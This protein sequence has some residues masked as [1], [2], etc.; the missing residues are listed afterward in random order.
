MLDN[1]CHK[2]VM[3]ASS[4]GLDQ[5]RLGTLRF[6]TAV[7]TNLSGDHLDY[8]KSMEEYHNAKEKLFTEYLAPEGKAIIN[9]DDS[10]ALK[11]AR[12]LSS[13]KVVT[14]GTSIKADCVFRIIRETASGTHAELRYAGFQRE[15]HSPLPGIHNIYNLTGA[16]LASVSMGVPPEFASDFFENEF[17][18]PGRLEKYRAPDGAFCFIDY[19]HTDDALENVLRVLKKICAGRLICV[20]G[21]GGDRDKAKRPRMGRVAAALADQIYITNDNPRSETPGRI[22]D[23]II[24]GIPPE[25]KHLKIIPDRAKAISDSVTKASKKDIV[26]IAGKGHEEYQEVNGVFRDFSDKAELSRCFSEVEKN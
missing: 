15:F 24:R 3:E 20:F 16:F 19:A 21:C 9:I 6:K 8:H 1:G 2:A 4:H 13:E 23:D 5:K 11:T 10:R 18:I 17:R 12:K 7:F 14:F 26:L 22:I 25:Y